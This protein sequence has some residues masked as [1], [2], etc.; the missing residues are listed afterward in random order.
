MPKA[1]LF[2]EWRRYVS[3]K[4]N[5]PT[6]DEELFGARIQSDNKVW[7]RDEDERE[8]YVNGQISERFTQE[9]DIRPVHPVEMFSQEYR[10][11]TGYY[12]AK[13]RMKWEIRK[14]KSKK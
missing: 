12:L 5:N 4:N 13:K 11:F 14:S 9:V 8:D 1:F 10:K 6:S 7:D 3:D 2:T